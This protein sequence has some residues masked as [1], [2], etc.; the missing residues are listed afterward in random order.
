MPPLFHQNVVV[1]PLGSG[2]R[3]NSVYIGDGR[4]GVL[5]DCGIST[6]QVQRRLAAIGL[7]DAPIDAVFI[8]HEHSDHVAAARVLSKKVRRPNGDA[9]PFFMTRGTE[10]SLN[11]KVRP[12]RIETI[13]PGREFPLFGWTVEP[14]SVPHDTWDPVGYGFN[15]GPTRVGVLT[16][17]G[18]PTRLTAAKLASWDAAVLEFN[19]D[20][21]MLLDGSYPWSLKQR[22]RGH[23]GHLS[24]EQ[25]GE[26]LAEAAQHGRLA[27]VMLAHLSEEN[28]HPDLALEAAYRA[29]S[30]TSRT[31]VSIRVAQQNEPIEPACITSP[32]LAET[33][34][35]APP[36]R[37]RRAA[38]DE[39]EAHQ[40][41]SL[42][43]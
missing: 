13:S 21:E 35:S 8:T 27:H 4:H 23:H 3:G 38:T 14:F 22:I 40:Q 19:H 32:L 34:R 26:L 39:G 10:Q 24:N 6:R 25:A 20:V 33:T 17:F 29:L 2:S 12:E 1:C 16:D 5:V 30:T 43:S 18:R 11:P 9:I 37:T 31:D 36:R 28:N 15:I 41:V 7:E 42:F